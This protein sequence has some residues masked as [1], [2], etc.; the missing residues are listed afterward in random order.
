MK[1][2]L[3]L[4]HLEKNFKDVFGAYMLKDAEFDLDHYDIPF[5]DYRYDNCLPLKLV[6]Y[7]KLGSTEADK[8]TFVHFYQDD[9]I[10]DGTYGIWN[11]LIRSNEFQK[12]FNFRKI[13]KVGGIICPDYSVYGD[14][15]E[16]LK[17]WN[18]ARS[19]TVGHYFNRLGIPAIP[20]VHWLGPESYG[21]CFAGLRKNSIYAVSTLGCLRSR[22]EYEL[23]YPGLIELIKRKQPKT[24]IVYGTLNKKI[25]HILSDNNVNYLFFPSEISEAMEVKHG[26]E[27]K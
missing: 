10:F 6:S 17:I 12:G 19:R 13:E 11:S 7:S 22:N 25:Q 2:N 16:Y 5:V 24:L 27:S 21:Y 14:M 3:E 1:Y 8:D 18:V 26:N 15:P 23:F 20:N 4:I 9:Y